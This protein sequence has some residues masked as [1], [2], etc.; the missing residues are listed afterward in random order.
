MINLRNK[1]GQFIKGNI[2]WSKGIKRPEMSG[3][4]HPLFGKHHTQETK[5][6]IKVTKI[7]QFI[8][9]SGFFK[10]KHHSEESIKKIQEARK[11]QIGSKCP[12][13]KGGIY[14][15]NPSERKRYLVNK[16]RAI[17]MNAEGSH[18][19]GEWELLKKQYGY[20]C[21]S[22]KRKEPL[23][24]LTE[25]HIIPLIKGGSDYIENI[26]PLCKSC[27]STK[28]TNITCFKEEK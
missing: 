10:G 25:D 17:K 9:K 6:K 26:Q 8:G 28:H 20:T 2:P 15:N 11:K 21:L 3:E 24:K 16:R 27:N 13:W 7:Q 5:D 19:Q 4:K 14:N 1:K 18:T 22:C 12:A 23:I